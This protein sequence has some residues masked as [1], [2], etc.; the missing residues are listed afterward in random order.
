MTRSQWKGTAVGRIRKRQG[1]SGD[2][3]NIAEARACF[4]GHNRT[5]PPFVDHL[6]NG[7]N[8]RTIRMVSKG[9]VKQP[10]GM[11]GTGM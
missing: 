4:V 7:D 11:A 3:S 9:G 1:L 2:K 5:E 10:T 8:P 6:I